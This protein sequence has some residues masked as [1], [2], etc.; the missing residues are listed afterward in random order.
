LITTMRETWRRRVQRADQLST[1]DT[2]SRTLVAF[3]AALLRAQADV[4]DH[5]T[6]AG[7]WQPSGALESDLSS[8]RPQLP[9]ILRAVATS[10]SAS[11]AIEA[12][13]LLTSG[14]VDLD[15]TLRRFWRKPADDQFFAK[16]IVQPYAQ[17]LAERGIAPVGR[18]IARA[19]NR[20]PFCCGAPQLSV[21]CGAN[22]SA[23]E[24]GARALQCATCLMTWPFRRALCPQCGEEDER[25]LGYFT[26]PA[27]D[28]LRLETCE[29]CKHYLKGV[30]LTRLGVAVPLVDE[31]AGAPLDAWAT[32]HGFVKIELNLV[33][34]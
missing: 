26:T 3:Y 18:E 29:T 20:C 9:K 34:L 7:S 31:V 13:R 12:R 15:D 16:A 21:L 5:L 33:G 22:D 1:A 17:R 24:G 23:L 4:Y 14:A 32:E 10:G 8:L 2:T 6:A 27:F 30:D 19:A 11:L 25:K 28:H